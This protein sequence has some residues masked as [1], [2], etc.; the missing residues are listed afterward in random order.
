M[1]LAFSILFQ[2]R[3]RITQEVVVVAQLQQVA[4]VQEALEVWVAEVLEVGLIPQSVLLAQMVLEEAVALEGSQ[5]AQITHQAR[6][7]QASS[8]SGTRF[9]CV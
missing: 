6:A 8:S 9:R 3:P 5:V 2:G 1:E 4:A 7:V